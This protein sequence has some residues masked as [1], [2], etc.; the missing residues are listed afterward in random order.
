M[1][2]HCHGAAQTQKLLTAF[3]LTDLRSACYY[4]G[5]QYCI[6]CALPQV[7]VISVHLILALF[8]FT[9]FGIQ[10]D[11]MFAKLQVTQDELVDMVHPDTHLAP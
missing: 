4:A 7:A 1:A 9:T 5:C 3:S 8:P 6:T 11:H 2:D 10:A